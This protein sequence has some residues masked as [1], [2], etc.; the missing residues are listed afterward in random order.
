MKLHYF[1]LVTFLN[2]SITV[3]EFFHWFTIAVTTNITSAGFLD[4]TFSF[5]KPNND[6]I[7]IDVNSNHPPQILKRLPKSISKRLSE[8]LSS[9]DVF[10]K[11]KTLYEK[12]LDNSGF[13]E[14]LIDHQDN[15]KKI[16][17]KRSRNAN[18]K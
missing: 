11:S 13:Y 8:N 15:G 7:Y 18:A 16:N 14:N 10:D 2:Q 5:R 12:S 17:I 3:V 9:K 4:L 6:P 1:S